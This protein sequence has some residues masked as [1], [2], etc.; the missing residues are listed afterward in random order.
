M[1]SFIIRKARLD[2][3]QNQKT[4]TNI[5]H[6][7]NLCPFKKINNEVKIASDKIETKE[8]NLYLFEKILRAVH[9]KAW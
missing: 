6:N 8:N 5:K 4:T 9:S 7:Q 1:R 3:T 2:E